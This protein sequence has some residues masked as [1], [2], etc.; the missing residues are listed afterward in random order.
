MMGINPCV[1]P[2][3]TIAGVQVPPCP[4]IL[5]PGGTL[6]FTRSQRIRLSVLR[7]VHDMTQPPDP[8]HVIAEIV[9]ADGQLLASETFTM[10]GPEQGAFLEFRHPGGRGP[11]RDSRLEVYG[12]VRFTPGQLV[13]GFLAAVNELTDQTMSGIAPCT[14]PDPA[15]A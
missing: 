14:F 2:D 12:H 6:G 11:E 9:G 15:L 7:H 8:F 4:P 10:L 1:F 3:P 5:V 13:G